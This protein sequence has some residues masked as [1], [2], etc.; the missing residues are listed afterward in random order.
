LKT[1]YKSNNYTK[2]LF[3]TPVSD[4]SGI[5]TFSVGSKAENLNRIIVALSDS[6]M[7][8]AL[9]ADF[10]QGTISDIKFCAFEYTVDKD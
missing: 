6:R 10:T 8:T 4:L 3:L 5:G 2:D 7:K 9:N 1:A